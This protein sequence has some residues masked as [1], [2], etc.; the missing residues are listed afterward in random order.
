[1]LLNIALSDFL[2]HNQC[3]ITEM[4]VLERT[5]S[6]MCQKVTKVK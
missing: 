1:M 5:D 3:L 2:V 6:G 4:S